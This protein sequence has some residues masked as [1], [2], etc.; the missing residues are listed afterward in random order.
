[1]TPTEA[2]RIARDV[3]SNPLGRGTSWRVYGPYYLDQPRGPRTEGQSDN[4]FKAR[5]WSKEWKLSL[6]L[7]LIG[8]ANVSVTDVRWMPWERAVYYAARLPR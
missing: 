1:M 7:T 2:I 4:Y 3:V 8:R 5:Q 6:A